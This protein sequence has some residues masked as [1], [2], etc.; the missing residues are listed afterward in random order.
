MTAY[1]LR[2][3]GFTGEIALG[4]K[5]APKGYYLSGNRIPS[6]E[7]SIRLTLTAPSVAP[8]EPQTLAVIGMGTADGK[9]IAHVAV[10]AEDMMQAFAYRHLVPAQELKVQVTGR[11]A[12]LRVLSKMPVAL[13]PDGV[14]RIRIGT[15]AARAVGEVK[16]GVVSTHA[17]GIA[18]VRCVSGADYVE[19]V[20][21]CDTSKVKPGTQG[22]PALPGLR[23]THDGGQR[24]VHATLAAL[25]NWYRAG[26]SHEA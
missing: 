10:P 8:D 19:V 6:N 3:D 21:S 22:K 17:A 24:E 9:R 16:L 14:T 25:R 13:R 18:V 23:R 26:D 7:E 5:D 2:R 1:A 12:S 4:L 20:L 11:A 15:P